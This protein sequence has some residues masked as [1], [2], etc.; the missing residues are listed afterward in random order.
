MFKE[1][2]DIM[3]VKQLADALNIGTNKA[4]ELV[5]KNIIGCKRVGKRILIPKVCVVSYAR[6]ALYS[7]GS[8]Q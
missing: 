7:V 8:E 4:Y 2:P 3:T 1:Y 5:N 6:S